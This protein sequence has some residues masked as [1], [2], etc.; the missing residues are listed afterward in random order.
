MRST[1]LAD[2]LRDERQGRRR[3]GID[4]GIYMAGP[5]RGG[6]LVGETLC[7]VAGCHFRCQLK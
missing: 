6:P 1:F 3:L 2:E 4:R 5:G 7:R